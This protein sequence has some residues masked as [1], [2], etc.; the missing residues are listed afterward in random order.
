MNTLYV[1]DLDGTLFNKNKEISDN[2]ANRINACIREGMLFTVATARM[3]YGCDYRLENL[4]INVPGIVTNG[5]FLYDFAREKYV[6]AECMNENT[7]KQV[8]EAFR[9]NQMS[10]FVYLYKEDGIRIYYDYEFMTDQTQYFSSRAIEKCR[11]VRLVEDLEKVLPGGDVC[12]I[13]YTGAEEVL[14]PVCKKLDR[15]EK[16]NYSFYLNIYNGLYCLEIFSDTANK[17]NALKRLKAMLNCNQTVVFGDNYNDIPMIEI[18]DRSYAPE[19]ALKE[20]K[21]IVTGI[22]DDCDH[23]GVAKFMTQEMKKKFKTPE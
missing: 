5:V 15:I 13:A 3:P 2:S 7:T 19:N 14:K 10:C 20:V 6:S 18:A 8:I 17:Q 21:N 4:N 1:S 16:I 12:Y 9:E 11:E 23:D 22:L